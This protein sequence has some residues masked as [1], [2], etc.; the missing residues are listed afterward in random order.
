MKI[1]VLALTLLLT[2]VSS[3]CLSQSPVGTAYFSN[4]INWSQ[5]SNAYLTIIGGQPNACGTLVTFRNGSWL[6]APGWICTDSNGNAN[7]GPWTWANTPADQTDTN[8]RFDWPNGTAT[9]T[10]TGHVWDKTCPTLS[11]S[12]ASPIYGF[13]G[14][15]LDNQWGAGFDD[16]WTH[17][18]ASYYD[19]TTGRYYE[20][21]NVWYDSF[22]EVT[23]SGTI[24]GMPSKGITWSFNPASGQSPGQGVHIS[25]HTYI[26]KIYLTDGD[27]SCSPVTLSATFTY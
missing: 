7:A 12:S 4:E 26:W 10:T 3:I 11:Y 23:F 15:G 5:T 9:Y 17:V 19:Q 20:P 22:P 8:I 13:N 16:G 14:S 6:T 18:S 25:G 27:T 1:R 2:L 21:V 24:S